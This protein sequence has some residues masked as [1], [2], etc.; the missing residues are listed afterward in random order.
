M[1]RPA[2]NTFKLW[3][4]SRLLIFSLVLVAGLLSS[5]AI[6]ST[7]KTF[8]L[9]EEYI[10]YYAKSDVDAI[11]Q[12]LKGQGA[13]GLAKTSVYGKGGNYG[14]SPR[15]FQYDSQA[16][17][18][19]RKSSE[20]KVVTYI[21][22]FFCGKD[23]LKNSLENGDIELKLKAEI[24]LGSNFNQVR[25]F[26]DTVGFVSAQTE[27]ASLG[28]NSLKVEQVP[29][30][31]LPNGVSK[32][33]PSRNVQFQNYN[34]LLNSS[35]NQ[36]PGVKSSASQSA[37]QNPDQQ[38]E[39]STDNTPS[40]ESG[41]NPLSW[42]LCPIINTLADA[43]DAI[44]GELVQPLLETKP[45][46]LTEPENDPTNTFE[47][48]ANFRIYGNVILVIALLVLIFGQS[49]GG[50]LVD[51]YTAKKMLPRVVIAAILIN[52][53]IYIVALG[54][55]IT[56]IIGNGIID[57][58]EQP[59]K[60]AGGF[61]YKLSGGA[62]T[63]GVGA[64][65]TA[66]FWT[67]AA[68]VFFLEWLLAFFLLPAFLI[69]IA[70]MAV[71]LIRHGLILFLILIAPVAFAL[72]CLP[73]TEK[74]FRQWWDLLLKTLLVYPIIA[75]M[76]AIANVLS[77]TISSTASGVAEVLANLLSIFALFV[78][79]ALIPFSFR[80]AGGVLGRIYDFANNA[81]KRTHQG[82]LGAE[83]DPDSWRRRS[84]SKLRHR[85]QEQGLDAKG[86]RTNF[87]PPKN[88]LTS[89]GRQD[90]ARNRQTRRAS[91]RILSGREFLEHD[92]IARA[93][94]GSD[95]YYT[96]VAHRGLAEQRLREA[97]ASG[98]AAGANSWR[99]A[100]SNAELTP[101]TEAIRMAAAEKLAGTGFIFSAGQKGYNE[102]AEMQAAIT[103]AQL[104]RD[105]DGNVTGATGGREGAWQD[106]MDS[107]QY[108]LKNGGRFDLA[109]INR[110]SGWSA[111]GGLDKAGGWQL[112][113]AKKETFHGL[114]QGVLGA[115]LTSEGKTA[116][117]EELTS[118]IMQ[119]IA[120][121]RISAEDAA[122][123]HSTLLD[124]AASPNAGNKQEIEKQLQAI[125][126]AAAGLSHEAAPPI[127][128]PNNRN[129]AGV[130]QAR[131]QENIR[132]R[133]Q[134]PDPNDIESGQGG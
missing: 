121:G 134:R 79:L 43:I 17:S 98:D 103:G 5:L 46:N 71:V 128:D 33:G 72:Y 101:N 67:Y 75:T 35:K 129:A 37:D 31:C 117:Q 80:L 131:V 14:N 55:D 88:V 111:K 22:T 87:L 10:L 61:E 105:A 113:Q 106:A 26:N 68:G 51:A 56:N 64:I 99:Q 34:L 28:S 20:G 4:R 16:T 15:G 1:K 130:F 25:V 118:Q 12:D 126:G 132:R 24:V 108:N 3:R 58:I 27:G 119:N 110:G 100:I 89:R 85:L 45:V 32:N 49:I 39:T 86:M 122:N 66:G 65:L 124:A 95:Q 116:S 107:M 120:T 62:A 7:Q 78:P 127:V 63:L 73:N 82:I 81:S 13:N 36:W 123:Y 54:I 19:N 8:A 29:S 76:F 2:G 59:F 74:Y 92:S 70:I 93:Q 44:Y 77:V 30:N 104:T 47:I 52:L 125:Q 42:I 38:E 50:G 114:A 115:R 109:G 84:R 102:V 94:Q 9:G 96:A 6:T 23:G 97:E 57:L 112:G 60:D 21:G 90:W 40:C 48:W 69:M 11:K 53:S 83:N 41:G 91:S 133:T 18:L